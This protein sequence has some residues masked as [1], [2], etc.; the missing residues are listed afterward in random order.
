MGRPRPRRRVLQAGGSGGD[1]VRGEQR[2]VPRVGEPAGHAEQRIPPAA[3]PERGPWLLQRPRTVGDAVARVPAAGERPALPHA[4]HHLEGLGQPLG[5]LGPLQPRVAE[6]VVLGAVAAGADPEV[7][8]AVAQVVQGGRRA[9][10]PRRVPERLGQH[11]RAAPDRGRGQ[12]H[13]GEGRPRLPHR[14]PRRHRNDPQVVLDPDGVVPERLG[15]P[16][17]I[18]DPGQVGALLGDQDPDLHA[19]GPAFFAASWTAS[20]QSSAVMPAAASGWS[21][22][23]ASRTE[24]TRATRSSRSAAFAPA[25]GAGHAF[26]HVG[27]GQVHVAGHQRAQDRAVV[28]SATP[29]RT[30]F[31]PFT[32]AKPTRDPGGAVSV[33]RDWSRCAAPS[34]RS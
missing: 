27:R 15:E 10:Q 4:R 28:V 5:A 12:Q 18:D 9:G 3:D 33:N 11:Q 22:S 25:S 21:T 23:S 26:H 7:Q 13:G 31:L 34:R 1:G 8:P 30:S 32:F 24:R 29:A 14:A 16:G 17:M 20:T 19:E 6:R 2:R